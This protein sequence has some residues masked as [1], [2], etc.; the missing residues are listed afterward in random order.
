[1]HN[2][3]IHSVVAD[4]QR[5]VMFLSAWSI[6]C[7]SINILVAG[8]PFSIM[9]F[10][11]PLYPSYQVSGSHSFQK[12]DKPWFPK[13]HRDVMWCGLKKAHLSNIWFQN[14]NPAFAYFCDTMPKGKF[15]LMQIFAQIK[16]KVHTLSW[17]QFKFSVKNSN[18]S[19]LQQ[20]KR[21]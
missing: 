12:L 13:P 1:M 21:L 17:F 9:A 20:Q 16:A 6:R 15:G 4:F 5:G 3:S 8:T 2:D 11:M 14:V 10:N 18:A 19:F 7:C